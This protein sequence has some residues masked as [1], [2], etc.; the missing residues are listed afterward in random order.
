MFSKYIYIQNFLKL[1]LVEVEQKLLLNKNNF[2]VEVEQ[3]SLLNEI[4]FG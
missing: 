2:R 4:I 1:F 3:I